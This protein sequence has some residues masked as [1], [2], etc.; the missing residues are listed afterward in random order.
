MGTNL[1]RPEAIFTFQFIGIREIYYT[2]RAPLWNTINRNALDAQQFEA[3]VAG[4]LM[5][6]ST[7]DWKISTV[8]NALMV[9]VEAPDVLA[10]EKV[11]EMEHA[12]PNR[13][14]QLVNDF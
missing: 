12:K 5:D 13:A 10:F 7:A 11:F 1:R 6:N 8:D 4:W 14:R 2:Y 9:F 3:E